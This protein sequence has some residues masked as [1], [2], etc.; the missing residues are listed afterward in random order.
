[1]TYCTAAEPVADESGTKL[2]GILRRF[3][4]ELEVSFADAWRDLAGRT[5]DRYGRAISTGERKT[6]FGCKSDGSV[7]GDALEFYSPVLQGDAGLEA[8]E[9]LCDYAAAH[10]WETDSSCGYHL[11]IDC[12]DLNDEQRKA[13]YYAY[14]LTESL[15]A[16]FVPRNRAEE[17][18][19]CRKINL[20]AAQIR[21][22]SFATTFQRVR[23]GPND[24][25]VWCNLLSLDR[26]STIEIRLHTGT[27]DKA[28]VTNWIKAHLSFVETVKNMTLEQID[29]A[30]ADKTVAG[31]FLSIERI[32][33]D[34]G[35]SEFYRRRAKRVSKALHL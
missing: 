4:V 31:Q 3:G 27:V 15:W 13:V 32:W 16:R 28:Q 33:Q 17:N 5:E 22:D 35:L 21:Q 1:M 12:G 8:V 18:T 9:N 10:A 7:N 6:P 24:R 14:K 30:F 11:H 2:G 20:D 34:R 23:N 26:H 25:Y 19:Y 29:D